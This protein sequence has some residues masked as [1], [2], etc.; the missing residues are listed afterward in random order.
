MNESDIDNEG[1]TLKLA[2]NKGLKLIKKMAYFHNSTESHI[3][4]STAKL[5]FASFLEASYSYRNFWAITH[6]VD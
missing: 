4:A 5:H 1:F 3:Q 2:L 6:S